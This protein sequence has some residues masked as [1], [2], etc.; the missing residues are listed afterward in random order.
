MTLQIDRTKLQA[1]TLNIW[2]LLG[3]AV[4][5][6]VGCLAAFLQLIAIEH[7]NMKKLI[8]IESKLTFSAGLLDLILCCLICY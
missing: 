2:M 4:L 6:L 3:H 5:L 7:L 8:T 1:G